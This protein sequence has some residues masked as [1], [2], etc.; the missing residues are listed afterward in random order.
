MAM[1]RTFNFYFTYR[2]SR[3]LK[4]TIM[5]LL[6]PF[7]VRSAI[8]NTFNHFSHLACFWALHRPG[9][10]IYRRNSG[11]A[12]WVDRTGH[13]RCAWPRQSKTRANPSLGRVGI[14]RSEFESQLC[15]SLAEGGLGACPQP[16]HGLLSILALVHVKFYFVRSSSSYQLFF[17]LVHHIMYHQSFLVSFCL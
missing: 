14:K 16:P 6:S 13:L 10:V 1:Q 4:M 5:A 8:L 7:Y 3:Y 12:R 11:R 2:Y 15:L 9:A 17:I